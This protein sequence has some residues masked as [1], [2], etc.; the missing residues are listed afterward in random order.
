MYTT[1]IKYKPWIEAFRFNC[2]KAQDREY[3]SPYIIFSSRVMVPC[4]ISSGMDGAWKEIVGG[5]LSY[6]NFP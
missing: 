3:P 4:C 2:Q 6:I 1:K 5:K